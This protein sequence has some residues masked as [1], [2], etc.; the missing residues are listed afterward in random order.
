MSSVGGLIKV[1]DP[2]KDIQFEKH[3][4]VWSHSHGS[5]LSLKLLR[6]LDHGKISKLMSDT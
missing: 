6:F 1:A 3:I 4:L 2:V 5:Q